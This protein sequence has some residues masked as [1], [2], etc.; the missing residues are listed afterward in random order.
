LLLRTPLK[1]HLGKIP[2]SAGMIR[3]WC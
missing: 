2:C 1:L 3:K